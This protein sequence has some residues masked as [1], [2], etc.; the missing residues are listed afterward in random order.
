MTDNLVPT[1]NGILLIDKP[2]GIT[3]H[4]IIYKLRKILNIRRIGH[5]GTLDPLATG[6]MIVLIGR[7]TKYSQM[8]MDLNKCYSGTMKFGEET[9]SYDADGAVTNVYSTRHLDFEQLQKTVA[10][11][12]GE[13]F[14]I[15]PMFSA[16]KVN[17]HPLYKLAR[18][19]YCIERKP[20]KVNIFSFKVFNFFNDKADF[21][22]HC[23]KG[24]YIRSLVHDFGRQLNCGAHV[25]A[26]R[27]ISIGQFDIKDSY[28][29]EE[30]SVLSSIEIMKL[31]LNPDNY[32]E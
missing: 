15:P 32:F 20:V 23:S 27:R 26:L 8:F 6:L 16:K 7:A 25:C 14:Q 18:K 17:G 29:L 22:I 31:L 19:G 9:D 1:L 11:F 21:I 4:D 24:T 3:S 13:I 10:L 30:I 28:T 12:T 5:A 2:T